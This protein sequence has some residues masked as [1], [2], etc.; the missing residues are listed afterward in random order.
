MTDINLENFRKVPDEIIEDANKIVVE[1]LIS[2][3][4]TEFNDHM[5]FKWTNKSIFPVTLLLNR[6]SINICR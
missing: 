1:K 2:I 6:I 5:L 3:Q 4:Q